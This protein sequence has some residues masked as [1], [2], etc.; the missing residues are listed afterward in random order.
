VGGREREKREEREGVEAK[1]GNSTFY[2]FNAYR[3]S[4]VGQGRKR[5]INDQSLCL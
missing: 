2:L 4:P 3:A 1:S 5:R